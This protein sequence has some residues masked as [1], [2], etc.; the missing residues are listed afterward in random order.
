MGSANSIESESSGSPVRLRPRVFLVL[1]LLVGLGF[2]AHFVWKTYAPTVASH[3][4]YR[5]TTEGI[6]ITPPPLSTV[7]RPARSNSS[8]MWVLTNAPTSSEV[9]TGF[10]LSS[11]S[12]FSPIFSGSSRTCLNASNWTG[13]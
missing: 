2:A 5:V 9:V 8:R 1:A 4:Q 11:S 6:T 10:T 12:R 13:V 7:F 3:P